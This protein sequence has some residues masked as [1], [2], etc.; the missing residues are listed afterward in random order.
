MLKYIP[1]RHIKRMFPY[2]FFDELYEPLKGYT[3]DNPVF[4]IRGSE[5]DKK[6]SDEDRIKEFEAHRDIALKQKNPEGQ[7]LEE[8]NIYK[9]DQGEFLV[10]DTYIK[11]D[12]IQKL[13]NSEPINRYILMVQLFDKNEQ[14]IFST[15]QNISLIREIPEV[16]WDDPNL[17][18]LIMKVVSAESDELEETIDIGII[19][20]PQFYIDNLITDPNVERTESFG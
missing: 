5:L 17:A 3:P 14:P 18:I 10:L 9:L 1:N 2:A 4:L 6:M 8:F 11:R 7:S 12:D 13:I 15:E 20:A 16:L 19:K